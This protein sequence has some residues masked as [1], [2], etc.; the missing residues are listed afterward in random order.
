MTRRHVDGAVFNMRALG[1]SWE[2]MPPAS[3]TGGRDLIAISCDEP[4]WGIAEAFDAI[5]V[6]PSALEA[7]HGKVELPALP[8]LRCTYVARY[9]RDEGNGH[10]TVLAEQALLA[11]QEGVSVDLPRP[12]SLH[13]GFT[14]K[15]DE[16]L[17]IWVSG[18][19]GHLSVP[20]T[21]EWGFSS[22]NLTH[23]VVGTSS[24][25]HA[26]DLCN[27]PA[28]RSGPLAFIDPGAIHRVTI[29]GLP[30]LTRIFYR[31]GGAG[32]RHW[33]KE[34]SFMSRRAAPSP[35]TPSTSSTA[36]ASIKFLMYA[37][38][39]LPVPI[40]EGAWRMTKQVVA[41]IEAGYDAFLL[42]PG[43]LGY[44][45]GSGYI[46]DVWGAFVEPI[47]ARVPYMVT[48]GNHEYDHVGMKAEGSGAPAGGWHP[49]WGNLH[50]D[51]HGE[52][53]VPVSARFNGTGS[54]HPTVEG[55]NG[56]FWYSFEEG[57]VHM[58][59]EH[60]WTRGSPQYAWLARDLASV[61]RAATP[62]VVLATHRM[63]YTTQ[64]REQGD[65]NVSLVFRREVEPLLRQYKVNL[66][67]VGHQHSYER[68][69]AAYAGK[70]V[71]AGEH[72]TVH[73]VVG[74]AGASLERGTFD[75]SLGEF[76]LKHV[77]DWGY[78]RLDANEERIKVQFVRTR[79]W[80]QE[81]DE[82][83]EDERAVPTSSQAAAVDGVGGV[84]EGKR[85]PP[86]S[87][88]DEVDILPWV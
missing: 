12:T 25:Y 85:M 36:N 70:C 7:G 43:D 23:T 32:H 35:S 11:K 16:M 57:L 45:E 14:S 39:A 81:G 48:V 61:D 73:M 66:M 29:S 67:L 9:V 19:G 1:L 71:G 28:N 15:R 30:S 50:D 17:V 53:G 49:L 10:G 78:V 63:M 27:A 21:V 3:R 56:V 80:H 5:A 22:G 62:W 13:I 76:S 51:S 18:G 52:C 60:D 74:S 4:N 46:W 2:G 26:S 8:E 55:S 88:W 72:G 33:T 42:H 68:S 83:D 59:S 37:D 87:V 75:P 64:T 58:R 77:N 69:C 31:A 41:D 65:Y 6:P 47:T 79:A 20:P 34:H 86:G 84:R 44:A 38:Q 54:A 40:F 24:T 82:D